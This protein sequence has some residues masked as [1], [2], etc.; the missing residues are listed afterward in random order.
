MSNMET[1]STE[2]G[3][4]ASM[5]ELAPA[6]VLQATAPHTATLFAGI[7]GVVDPDQLR[8]HAEV[9]AAS[10]VLGGA[11]LTLA[12]PGS[13]TSRT[14]VNEALDLL[15]Y[16]L[17]TAE[18]ANSPWAQTAAAQVALLTLAA[19][20]QA[21]TVVLL[22]SDL[23]ALAP[24]ALRQLA[25]PVLLAREADL[26]MGSY[27]LGPFDG[28]LNASIL[29]PLTRALYG[30]RV[31]FPLAPDLALSP[32]M[33]ARLALSA[34]SRLRGGGTPVLWPTT[35]AAGIDANVTEAPLGIAH[36]SPAGDMELS[37]VIAQIVGSA[38]GEM[39]THAPLWQRI[40]PAQHGTG[41]RSV[42]HA[43]LHTATPIDTA[44]MIKSFLLGSRSLQDVW[45]LV[46]PP[47][48]LLDLKRLTLLAPDKFR[49]PDELWVRIVYD[50]ALGYRLRTIN[51]THLLGALTPLYLGWV[52]SFINEAAGDP[53]FDAGARAEKVARAFE[54]GKPYLVRRWRWPDRFNP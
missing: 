17:P 32:R 54:D 41:F 50:F 49:M 43:S 40:R 45:G 18:G 6:S 24:T 14:L 42:V 15:S 10:G 47:V 27:T 39:E 26:V 16:P 34:H 53:A 2:A 8:T 51:R 7:A 36:P 48:T 4:A 19:D 22:H 52:A 44:P 30:K 1:E 23:G 5:P 33:A 28:L 35:V 25:S 13:D 3:V 21:G 38:F 12:Y 9:L 31:R 11:H 46:L 29:A 20:A 37:A